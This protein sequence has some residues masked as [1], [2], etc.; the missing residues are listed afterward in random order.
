ML[1]LDGQNASLLHAVGTQYDLRQACVLNEPD[2]VKLDKLVIFFKPLHI[3]DFINITD[4]LKKL[5][6]MS[7]HLP[8]VLL[9]L[10]LNHLFKSSYNRVADVLLTMDRLAHIGK[11]TDTELS[12]A[13]YLNLLYQISIR[14][15]RRVTSPKTV[16]IKRLNMTNVSLYVRN[17]RGI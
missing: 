3:S 2:S 4:R 7:Q 15:F 5:F 12:V 11:P 13:K 6:V 8:K 17:L 1:K 10:N 9:I 14:S 16:M